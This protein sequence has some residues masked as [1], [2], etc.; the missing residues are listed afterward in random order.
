MAIKAGYID[1]ERVYVFDWMSKPIHGKGFNTMDCFV[2]THKDIVK[3][4][5]RCLKE[6]EKANDENMRATVLFDLVYS[7]E[8]NG[9][10]HSMPYRIVHKSE[11]IFDDEK[12]IKKTKLPRLNL[13]RHDASPKII[14]DK[15]END[16]SN[17]L[18]FDEYRKRRSDL[19]DD[20]SQ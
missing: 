11:V 19:I 6:I 17:V 1:N 5:N 13:P 9:G 10:K 2:L 14:Q 12:D 3:T 18:S 20:R 8:L 4:L 7:L 16:E 15:A